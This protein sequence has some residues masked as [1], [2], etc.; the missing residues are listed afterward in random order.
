MGEDHALAKFALDVTLL[1]QCGVQVIV[2][3][4]GGPQIGAMLDRLGIHSEFVGGHRVTSAEAVEV[5][6]MVLGGSVNKR[7]VAA[8][9]RQGGRAV[10]L[11]GKDGGM[12]RAERRRAADGS[13]LG[14]VGTPTVVDVRVLER[15]IDDA[16]I[17]VI[18]PIAAG[19]DGRPST[20]TRTR[21]PA[22]SR[23]PYPRSGSCS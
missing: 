5:V 4:G 21:R 10:G 20:S 15:L 6:E 8:I 14:F 13:D 18:A 19:A 1:R 3:H 7:I 2:V 9:Q 22:R 12:V 17:P 23:G 16:F 11:S